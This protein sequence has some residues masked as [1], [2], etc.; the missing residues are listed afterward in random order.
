MCEGMGEGVFG[1][2]L[3]D[4]NIAVCPVAGGDHVIQQILRNLS[5][6]ATSCA[7][8]DNHHLMTLHC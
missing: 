8:S 5:C 4:D 3:C 6:L 7:T 2:H 1:A